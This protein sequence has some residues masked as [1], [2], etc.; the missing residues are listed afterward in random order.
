MSPITSP[1]DAIYDIYDESRAFKH[2]SHLPEA[3]IKQSLLNKHFDPDEV[4]FINQERANQ[5]K[6]LFPNVNNEILSVIFD[7]V[8]RGALPFTAMISENNATR[9]SAFQEK[10][11]LQRMIDAY[12]VDPQASPEK[13]RQN[14]EDVW[15]NRPE[16]QVF[17]SLNNKANKNGQTSFTKKLRRFGLE[18]CFTKEYHSE[19][20][21]QIHSAD[22]LR[23]LTFKYLKG[24]LKDEK[25]AVIS[26]P[27]RENLLREIR[28]LQI[29]S[30]GNL[31][32]MGL[33]EMEAIFTQ[34]T[35]DGVWAESAELSLTA[36]LLDINLGVRDKT[37]K[38][39]LHTSHENPKEKLDIILRNSDNMHWEAEKRGEAVPTLGH[40]NCGYNA[41]ALSLRDLYHMVNPLK[42]AKNASLTRSPLHH[43][44]VERFPENIALVIEKQRELEDF[45]KSRAKSAKLSMKKMVSVLKSSATHIGLSPEKPKSIKKSVKIQAQIDADYQYA[46]KVAEDEY[47]GVDQDEM[48]GKMRGFIR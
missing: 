28:I 29:A 21:F 32:Q 5:L 33:K 41:L 37:S 25:N 12:Q 48:E 10:V 43:Q 39:K 26:G 22:I 13:C 44:E 9:L 8:A 7:I 45:Y 20:E 14:V 4:L 15:R 34:Q 35:A 46:L 42:K 6:S 2:S 38:I 3:D 17:L 11:L 27:I 1:R 19:R 18:Y 40:G 36:E 30:G 23:K 16:K 47:R 31:E 24:E